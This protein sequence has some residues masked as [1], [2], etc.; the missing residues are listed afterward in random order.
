MTCRHLEERLEAMLGGVLPPGEA[1]L[2][3]QHLA[4][5]GACRE[6]LELARLGEAAAGVGVEPAP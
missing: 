3:A 4:T 6:L 2:C 1:D 5:C